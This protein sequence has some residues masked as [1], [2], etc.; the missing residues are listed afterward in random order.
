MKPVCSLCG[1]T[2][3]V[4]GCGAGQVCENCAETNR[5]G[6]DQAT[7]QAKAKQK[8]LRLTAEKL[9]T[10]ATGGSVDPA[11]DYAISASDLMALDEPHQRPL[12]GTGGEVLPL[13]NPELCDTLT[14]PG[15]VALDASRDRLE[16]VSQ[17]G[18]DCTAMALDVSDTIQASNSLEKMLAHQ[19]ALTHKL[20]MD[21]AS[22]A[23]LQ[24][25]S[26]N[27]VKMLN[28]S[29]RAMQTFQCGLLALKKLRSTGEQRMTI[30]HV[31]V[32]DG[33]MAAFGQV[34]HRPI[35]EKI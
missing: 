2:D 3:A 11:I 19:L 16:L 32:T 12:M 27:S 4:T 35:G 18:T 34:Q 17:F 14:T 28:L 20:S 25:D 10:V 31:S 23:A 13:D 26:A 9:R 15:T 29:L 7:R 24:A 1:S 21:Y 8:T 30:A 22:K 6:R 33:G 5:V